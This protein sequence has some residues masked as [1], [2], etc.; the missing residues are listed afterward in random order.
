VAQNA[1]INHKGVF[2]LAYKRKDK[3]RNSI[4]KKL[5]DVEI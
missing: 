2:I 4:L 3:V 1:I 5:G